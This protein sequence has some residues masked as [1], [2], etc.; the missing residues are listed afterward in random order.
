[1]VFVFIP[2]YF[3]L[4]VYSNTYFKYNSFFVLKLVL[5][6][7]ILNMYIWKVFL[8][9]LVYTQY[10]YND[11][12]IFMIWFTFFTLFWYSKLFVSIII[13]SIRIFCMHILRFISRHHHWYNAYF[14]YL[15]HSDKM[16]IFY[17]CFSFARLRDDYVNACCFIEAPTTKR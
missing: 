13:I 12:I 5:T 2:K 8:T 16:C 4:K 7:F 10:Y 14:V 9:R 11:N 3:S 15:I 17:I 6:Y 1:M